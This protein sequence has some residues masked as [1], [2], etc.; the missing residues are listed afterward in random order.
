MPDSYTYLPEIWTDDPSDQQGMGS[1]KVNR[2]DVSPADI[3]FK[4]CGGTERDDLASE[5]PFV[6][7]SDIQDDLKHALNFLYNIDSFSV[8]CNAIQSG[9]TFDY[10]FETKGFREPLDR[11]KE[12]GTSSGT[13]PGLTIDATSG[14]VTKYNFSSP[15]V[16]FGEMS[17]GIGS[18]SR[19]TRM[20]YGDVTNEA[21]FIGYGVSGFTSA[22]PSADMG[23]IGGSSYASA[24]QG[25]FLR[26]TGRTF[27]FKALNYANVSGF[28]ASGDAFRRTIFDNVV[29]DDC[30]FFVMS[31]GQTFNI[32]TPPP[33]VSLGI[34]GG[35][36][37]FGPSYSNT[38]G[39]SFSIN[40]FSP[41]NWF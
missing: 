12:D 9:A 35:L 37:G 21:N 24:I 11:L 14:G 40:L 20:Y 36:G 6:S 16:V 41:V 33:Q 19:L 29:F 27:Y 4:T 17:I 34:S 22:I 39:D 7:A 8:I 5:A 3:Q 18:Q 28:E 1:V 32:G 30:N 10:H 25:Q 15:G 13:F 23:S 26:Q 38:T 2:V 31:A